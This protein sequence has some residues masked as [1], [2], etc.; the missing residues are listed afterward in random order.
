VTG[1]AAA[2]GTGRNVAR[3]IADAR[4]GR[5]EGAGAA[6]RAGQGSAP[7]APSTPDFVTTREKRVKRHNAPNGSVS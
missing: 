4:P 2:A 3:R 6:R 5:P 1:R 7:I